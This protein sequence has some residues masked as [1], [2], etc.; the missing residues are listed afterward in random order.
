MSHSPQAEVLLTD[1]ERRAIEGAAT[2][3]LVFLAD[4]E[5]L[6]KVLFVAEQNDAP[7]APSA[8]NLLLQALMRFTGIYHPIQ[9]D[10]AEFDQGMMRSCSALRSGILKLIKQN[11]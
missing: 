11:P 2:F 7:D 8:W 9:E 6:N 5:L 4:P 3:G 1:P 10:S